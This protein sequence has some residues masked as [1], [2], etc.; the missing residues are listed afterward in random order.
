MHT[1]ASLVLDYM[2]VRA[3]ASAYQKINT[4]ELSKSMSDQNWI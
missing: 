4:L 1:L 3:L 2:L